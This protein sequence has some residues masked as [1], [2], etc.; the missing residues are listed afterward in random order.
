MGTR[1][2]VALPGGLG[3]EAALASGAGPGAA[4]M[5]VDAPGKTILP[6]FF[7]IKVCKALR[8]ASTFMVEKPGMLFFARIFIS[9]PVMVARSVAAI[10]RTL[11]NS[12]T[13]LWTVIK[14]KQSANFK[15]F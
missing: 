15:S 9:A 11:S 3:S 12:T 14:H 6:G 7:S 8:N 13:C 5:L 10:G 2:R 1:A 4:A